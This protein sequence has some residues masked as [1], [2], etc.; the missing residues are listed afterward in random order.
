MEMI[1]RKIC[2]KITTIN[3]EVIGETYTNLIEEET[4]DMVY[5]S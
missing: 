3:D 4:E 2:E 5:A 1:K